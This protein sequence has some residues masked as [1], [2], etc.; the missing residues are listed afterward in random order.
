[1]RENFISALATKLS[2]GRA[3]AGRPI[4]FGLTPACFMHTGVLSLLCEDASVCCL[5]D[6][7][8]A[9]GSGALFKLEQVTYVG[10]SINVKSCVNV[11]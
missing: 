7:F 9:V 1:M 6:T 5:M 2:G 10:V 4:S 11:T 8:Y 3:R